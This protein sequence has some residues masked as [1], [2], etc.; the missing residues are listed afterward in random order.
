VREALCRALGPLTRLHSVKHVLYVRCSLKSPKTKVIGLVVYWIMIRRS[1]RPSGASPT[2]RNVQHVRHKSRIL[3][4]TTRGR[5]PS[6]VQ[7]NEL[8]QLKPN[9]PSRHKDKINNEVK[10][11]ITVKVVPVLNWLSTTPLSRMGEWMYR[12][13]FPWPRH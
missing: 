8:A 12:P 6:S 5:N 4:C 1:R 3:Y 10:V 13:M 11:I 9:I 2:K 7:R